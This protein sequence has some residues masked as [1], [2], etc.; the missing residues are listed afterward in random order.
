MCTV[1]P[2]NILVYARTAWYDTYAK[3]IIEITGQL[4]EH[5]RVLYLDY[6]FTFKDLIQRLLRGKKQPGFWRILGLKPRLQVLKSTEKGVLY[7]FT[8]PPIIPVQPLP[9]GP[10]YRFFQA[11]NSRRINKAVQRALKK[12]SMEQGLILFNSFNPEFGQF[13]KGEFRAEKHIYHCYDVIEAAPWQKR[14]GGPAERRYLPRVDAVIFTSHGLQE[15]KGARAQKSF[16]VENG[17]DFPSYSAA[18]CPPPHSGKVGYVGALDFRTDQALLRKVIEACPALHFE[19]V[20]PIKEAALEAYLTDHPRVTLHGSRPPEALPGYLA[21]WDAGIIPFLDNEFTAGVYPLKVNEYLAVG[22]PVVSTPFGQM[23]RFAETVHLAGEAQA[24]STA[25]QSAIHED[26]LEK[27]KKRSNF[28]QNNSW[29]A[30]VQEME[31]IIF[32]KE[33]KG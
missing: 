30:R 32:S 4:A 14:H 16:V 9:E 31:E 10:L 28:A 18:F 3:T 2:K 20:G 7:L 23:H 26:S 11:W 8:P 21:Q 19:F 15:Q 1:T 6:Q 29:E 22:L 25:L 17:V 12:L 33:G 5:H 24:F 13:Y 27:R